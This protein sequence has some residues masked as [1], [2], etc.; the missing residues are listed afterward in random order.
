M[1]IPV[2]LYSITWDTFCQFQANFLLQIS[3]K[4]DF[5]KFNERHQATPEEYMGN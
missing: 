4:L 5:C 3:W 2:S 1:P